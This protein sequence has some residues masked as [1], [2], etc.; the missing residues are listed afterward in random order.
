MQEYLKIIQSEDQNLKKNEKERRKPTWL[1]DEHTHT[2]THTH[3]NIH[4]L[5]NWKG[6]DRKFI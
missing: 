5:G 3:T 6:R 1:W 2:H 4:I